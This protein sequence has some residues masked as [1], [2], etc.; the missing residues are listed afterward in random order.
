MKY[1]Q[2]FMIIMLSIFVFMFS[3]SPPAIGALSGGVI[4][5]TARTNTTVLVQI[6][7]HPSGGVVADSVNICKLL[8][9]GTDTTFITTCDTLTTAKVLTSQ[10]PAQQ[11]IYFLLVRGVAG[12]TAISDKDTVTVYGPEIE[13][14]ATDNE[15]AYNEKMIRAT[16]WRPTSVLET[17]TIN[18]ST[19]KDSTAIYTPWDYNAVTVDASQA[20]D[21]V[22]VMLYVC[23]GSRT[24]TQIGATQGFTAAAESLNVSTEGIFGKTFTSHV[25]APSMYFRLNGYAGN[26][27][28]TSVVIW[29]N[30]RR[31]AK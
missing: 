20:G 11:A 2:F 30:R 28:N 1:K 3:S 7:T 21:S 8:I 10:I 14:D 12:L 25:A 6:T 9:G 16:S 31:D 5:T 4:T 26:G 13:S 27:K 23:Y 18:G 15:V 29:L 17:F 22:K 24:M 19:G